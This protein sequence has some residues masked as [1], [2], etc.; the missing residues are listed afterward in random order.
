MNT[1]RRHEL[2]QN[3]LAAYLNKANTYIE[4][5][6]KQIL[7]GVVAV[8]VIGI[9]YAFYSSEQ[10]AASSAATFQLIQRTNVENV[11]AEALDE[12]SSAYPDTA[13]GKLAKLYEGLAIVQDA[14]RD[15]YLEREIA[16]D[17]LNEGIRIL[18]ALASS[19]D[20]KLIKS[21]ANFGVAIANESLSELDAAV[22]AYEQVITIA[23]SEAMVEN[24]N[25]RIA[26][27]NRPA[28]KE[29]L[30][31]FKTEK[32]QPVASPNLDPSSPPTS[33]PFSTSIPDSPF[34]ETKPESSEETAPRDLDGGLDLPTEGDNNK[35]PMATSEPAETPAPATPAPATPAP[36]T[37]APETPAPETP[38]SET[39][40][41]ETDS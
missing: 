8:F 15:I 5:Y 21:R 26:S 27:L 39:P 23:E 12:I 25:D 6:S 14:T 41:S 35:A 3:E 13:S 10:E 11:D 7:V 19:S 34:L 37:P 31:W 18:T 2:Q 28:S 17:S 22:K 33:L 40:A 38:A 29:F 30:A 36:E 9:G 1:E 20:D 16:T 32:F 4:P 24:A